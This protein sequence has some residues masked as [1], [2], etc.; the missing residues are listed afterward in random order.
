MLTLDCYILEWPLPISGVFPFFSILSQCLQ[1]SIVLCHSFQKKIYIS[2][3]YFISFHADLTLEIVSLNWYSWYTAQEYTW[4]ISCIFHD[5]YDTRYC[6][7]WKLKIAVW[8]W[9]IGASTNWPICSRWHF[10]WN[11]NVILMKFPSLAALVLSKWWHFCF[12]VGIHLMIL[13]NDVLMGPVKVGQHWSRQN[14]C[15]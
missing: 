9:Q 10:H 14:C 7:V 15:E 6:F 5:Q 4:L 12:S 2:I 11:E 3:T 8:P 13:M 1:N